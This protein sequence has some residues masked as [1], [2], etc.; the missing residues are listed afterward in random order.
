MTHSPLRLSKRDDPPR[1]IWLLDDELPN[2]D[3]LLCDTLI[4]AM[5]EC[6]GLLSAHTGRPNTFDAETQH[7]R[8]CSAGAA[9]IRGTLL[10]AETATCEGLLCAGAAD[11]RSTLLYAVTVR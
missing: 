3:A 5:E 4:D 6:N 10:D 9:D 1:A 11:I 7:A 8:I 2:R